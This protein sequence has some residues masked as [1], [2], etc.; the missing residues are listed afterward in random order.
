MYLETSKFSRDSAKH[1]SGMTM[2]IFLSSGWVNWI[3]PGTLKNDSIFAFIV[4]SVVHFIQVL[5]EPRSLR[6]VI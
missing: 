3:M 6:Q 1:D 2:D 4:C 5:E